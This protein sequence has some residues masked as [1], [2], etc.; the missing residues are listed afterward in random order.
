MTPKLPWPGSHILN[1]FI[2]DVRT[3]IQKA[4]LLKYQFPGAQYPSSSVMRP[5]GTVAPMS[6]E[7]SLRVR[8]MTVFYRESPRL[9]PVPQVW[10]PK[11]RPECS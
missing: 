6:T 5:N 2:H 4:V 7:R 1:N 10:H 9:C 11:R 8:W 3:Q